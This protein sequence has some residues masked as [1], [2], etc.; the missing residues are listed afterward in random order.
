[1]PNQDS[2]APCRSQSRRSKG[3]SESVQVSACCMIRPPLYVEVHSYDTRKWHS[4]TY[5]AT[6]NPYYRTFK[7]LRPKSPVLSDDLLASKGSRTLPVF[8]R[9]SCVN[10]ALIFCSS[11]STAAVLLARA[12]K[13][14]CWA[15]RVVEMA[16][17]SQMY[18]L[19]QILLV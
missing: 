13:V 11:A 12:M 2:S 7:P 10:K 4:P 8:A 3:L 6:L 19:V 1:M 15:W 14:A 18:G 9:Q 5:I 17:R 16:T